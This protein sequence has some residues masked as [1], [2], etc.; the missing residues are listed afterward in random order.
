MGPGSNG[1]RPA[2]PGR[3]PAGHDDSSAASPR[4]ALMRSA[5][6]SPARPARP[7]AVAYFSLQP[8][9]GPRPFLRSS[10]PALP[11][12]Y[13]CVS[14][15]GREVR[16]WRPSRA[17]TLSPAATSPLRR[18]LTLMRDD[19]VDGVCAYADL[20]PNDATPRRPHALPD[21]G[22]SSPGMSGCCRRRHDFS[23]SARASNLD[24]AARLPAQAADAPPRVR[25]D[26]A[27]IRRGCRAS[28]HILVARSPTWRSAPSF[29]VAP[30]RAGRALRRGDH[31]TAR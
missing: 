25:T 21:Q 12:G 4:S 15:G 6:R 31:L 17:A 10:R 27:V 22:V 1:A 28:R 20:E 18:R 9:L 5:S 19:A 3:P 7:L 2:P 30:A 29:P 23:S 26:R 24:L 11:D 16:P 8:E 14:D 13:A